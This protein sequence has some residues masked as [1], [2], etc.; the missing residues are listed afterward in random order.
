MTHG[1]KPVTVLP[2][3]IAMSALIRPPV[4]QVKAVP[5]MMPFGAAAPRLTI[6]AGAGAVTVTVAVPEIVPLGAVTVL[7]KVPVTPPA[8][9]RPVF[10]SMLP[11]PFAT[12]Q[13]GEIAMTFPLPSRAVAANCWVLLVRTE[14]GLGVTVMLATTGVT[15][16]VAEPEM[17]PLVARTVLAYV[18]DVLPA[19]KRPVAAPIVPPPFAI[20]HTGVS[21]T[22]LPLASLPVA[23]NCWVPPTASVAGVGV[24]VMVASAPEVT[25]TVAVLVKLPLVAMTVLVYVCGDVPAVNSPVGLMEPP[26]A[27]TDQTGVTVTAAPEKSVPR[28]ENCC[29]PLIAMVFG[30]GE[31][32]IDDSEPGSLVPWTSQAT[33]NSP[34]KA[35][36]AITRA[37]RPFR[38]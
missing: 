37:A 35:A 25:M 32:V 30:F 21:T 27:T 15:V 12:A 10:A 38:G 11:P 20:D 23:V 29:V 1:G 28:A 2:G 31:I 7:L 16:T 24:T 19:V 34:V 14:A 13:T 8:V 33:T 4:T 9:K 17:V 3:L 22:A 5:A 26:P 18:P 36:A 6:G